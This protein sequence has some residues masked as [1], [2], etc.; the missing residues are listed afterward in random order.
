MEKVHIDWAQLQFIEMF[1][2]A[3]SAADNTERLK[4][5]ANLKQDAAAHVDE[6]I[7]DGR[8]EGWISSP[9]NAELLRRSA[10]TASARRAAA[11]EFSH[12]EREFEGSRGQGREK[13]LNIA[14][15]IGMRVLLTIKEEK[16]EGLQTEIGIL[17]QVRHFAQQEKIFGAQDRD[18]L[19]KTWGTYRG[20]VHLGMAMELY[21]D[22][23]LPSFDM[24]TLAEKIRMELSR[25]SPRSSNKPYVDE[26]EQISFVLSQ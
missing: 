18:T 3:L 26:G 22:S 19:S 21:G 1:R 8:G 23:A 17:E 24:L 25:H 16:F 15:H 4:A 6:L 12:T 9:A 14:E 7:V 13:K 20:V 2:V 10:L 11:G 5:I